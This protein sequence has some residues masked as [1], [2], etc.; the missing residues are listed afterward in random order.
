[1]IEDAVYQITVTSALRA[2]AVQM[3]CSLQGLSLLHCHYG[4]AYQMAVK[5]FPPPRNQ[6]LS[7]DNGLFQSVIGFSRAA[8]PLGCRL[9][10]QLCKSRLRTV[11]FF[12]LNATF[13]L[14]HAFS[15]SLEKQFLKGYKDHRMFFLKWKCWIEW[16]V[17][18]LGFT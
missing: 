2:F 9:G 16:H 18:S 7:S 10:L 3:C 11:T 12:S 15:P 8:H 13:S 5:S 14:L 6:H 1:M 4:G 17:G